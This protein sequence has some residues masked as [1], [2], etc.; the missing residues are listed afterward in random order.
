MIR[1]N[2][3]EAEHPIFTEGVNAFVPASWKLWALILRS[4]ASGHYN[5]MK[6]E[7]EADSVPL[8]KGVSFYS[9]I[10]QLYYESC[11]EVRAEL[12]SGFRNSEERHCVV[13]ALRAVAQD[14]LD[15]FSE[16]KKWL[17]PDGG[18]MEVFEKIASNCR[19]ILSIT[20]ENWD[21]SDV[22]SPYE[23]PE[24]Y[25][26]FNSI[27]VE[28]WHQKVNGVLIEDIDCN[29]FRHVLNCDGYVNVHDYET[30]SLELEDYSNEKITPLAG[31]G[32]AMYA[33]I[34][35][36]IDHRHADDE[37]IISDGEIYYPKPW[38]SLFE[39]RID[40]RKNKYNLEGDSWKSAYL[41]EKPQGDEKQDSSEADPSES[42]VDQKTKNQLSELCGRSV[43]WD[44]CSSDSFYGN[45]TSEDPFVIGY[46]VYHDIH[47]FK[48]KELEE[49]YKL[50]RKETDFLYENIYSIAAR[51]EDRY[52]AERI[53]ETSKWRFKEKVKNNS[54]IHALYLSFDSIHPETIQR[55]LYERTGF[56]Y[57]H[58]D[59]QPIIY[60]EMVEKYIKNCI[61]YNEK[62]KTELIRTLSECSENKRANEDPRIREACD[63]LRLDGIIDEKNNVQLKTEGGTNYRTIELTNF[64]VGHEFVVPSF[65]WPMVVFYPGDDKSTDSSTG[66]PSINT[67]I[68]RANFSGFEK[69]AYLDNEG[70]F[71]TSYYT[72]GLKND[73][74]FITKQLNW[75]DFGGRFNING[76][77][78]TAR[79][80]HNAFNSKNSKRCDIIRELLE[81]YD[82]PT[83]EDGCVISHKNKNNED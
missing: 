7:L 1:R 62:L 56:A 40:W 24:D 69:Q 23:I 67:S 55:L 78:L 73:L 2:S 10:M 59:N 51:F 16:A 81:K 4:I 82:K 72:E 21:L 20:D 18:E 15:S 29:T 11:E 17:A 60:R 19:I 63:G 41:A 47:Y 54:H 33:F 79:D 46:D 64:L 71:K 43:F 80:L 65:G 25:R 3:S 6:S 26:Y 48:Q 45:I 83:S 74:A 39:S 50:L 75:R 30:D 61:V 5:E 31:L 76:K 34:L 12:P 9:S 13:E 38:E 49:I 35:I 27:N 52:C 14:I 8:V 37:P 57:N 44:V 58:L 77:K 36:L 70:H 66:D 22:V 68:K 28:S 42:D 53:K 32:M